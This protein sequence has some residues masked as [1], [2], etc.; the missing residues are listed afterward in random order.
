MSKLET[1]TTR[2]SDTG[3]LRGG[4]VGRGR[5]EAGGLHLRQ[6]VQH[7]FDEDQRN[8]IELG[9]FS[10]VAEDLLVTAERKFKEA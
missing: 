4:L 10:G 1:L 6:E 8:G 2:S 5:G 9:G 3:P 7:I